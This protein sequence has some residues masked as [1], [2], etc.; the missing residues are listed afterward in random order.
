MTNR[1]ALPTE[2]HFSSAFSRSAFRIAAVMMTVALALSA[3]PQY[4][5]ASTFVVN[6]TADA[7]G[8]CTSGPGGCTLREAID[9]ANAAPGDDVVLVPAGTYLLNF[10][11]YIA[12]NVKL[13]GSGQ[14]STIIDGQGITRVLYI[15]EGGGSPVYQ[16]SIRDL[17]LRNGNSGAALGG[18]IWN[19]GTTTLE[20]VSVADNRANSQA[21]IA[22]VFNGS[23]TV[24]DSLIS[25][26]DAVGT[27]GAGGGI[28]SS[29]GN[30]AIINSTVTGNDAPSGLGGGLY[31]AGG[32]ASI[33]RSLISN[34]HVLDRG[35]GLYFTAPITVT[36]TTIS[37][38]SAQGTTSTSV[39]TDGGG[40]VL[41]SGSATFANVTIFNNS[42]PGT[43][44]AGFHANPGG[45]YNI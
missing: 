22:N 15:L 26:N 11:L 1:A 16:V 6:S 40:G 25:N 32:S 13:Q 43:K 17:T 31:I 24:I 23:L 3:A 2:F 8:A 5:N 41:G 7:S 27:G 12:S 14:T 44:T 33:D 45:P 19:G 37:G 28:T 38:N 34:N 30:V 39:P 36:N 35:G 18:G 10:Q 42:A 4:A 9:A 20:R 21:G 29:G